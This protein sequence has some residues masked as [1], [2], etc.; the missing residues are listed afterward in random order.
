MKVFLVIP[1]LSAGGAERVMSLLAN[2]WVTKH[3]FDVH[4]ILLASA[5][6]FYEVD[7]RV[8]IH[9]L[10][11]LANQSGLNKYIAMIKTF[12]L[13]RRLITKE[14]PIYIL[15]FMTNYNIFSL[16]AALGKKVKVFV[17][18]RD[19][20]LAYKSIF[21]KYLRRLIY[22]LAQG[23]IAQTEDYK[24]FIQKETG[25][26]N[27]SVIP[28][29]LRDT[30]KNTNIQ[31]EKIVLNVG[32]LVPQKGH[33]L[34]LLAFSLIEDT[35]DWVLVILGDGP[36]RDELIN[37][38]RELGIENKVHFKGTIKNVD[39][40]LQQSSIFA[41][42]SISEGFPNALAEAMIAGLPCVSFNC[43]AGPKDLIQDG[44]NGFLVEPENVQLFAN[45]LNILM[46]NE[47]LRAQ[48]S[49]EARKIF[50]TIN[51]A[52]ICSRYFKVMIDGNV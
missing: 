25:H 20:P 50:Q 34:L 3:M 15:S 6:D 31:K 48:F 26:A 49:Y 47:S 30:L 4:L 14:K 10:G 12:F 28:N 38:A 18:E 46:V 29:P 9:R 43:I 36:L 51:E 52:E 22:P 33:K 11:F 41:F 27:I 35:K 42:S 44:V 45:K 19:S 1:T 5:D 21:I 8:V 13:L 24:I 17:S 2:D 37:Y 16:L 39:D 7:E 40:W 32:R 23:I